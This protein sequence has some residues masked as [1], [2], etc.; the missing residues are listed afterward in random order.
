MTKIFKI[1][2]KVIKIF[3]E[4]LKTPKICHIFLNLHKKRI[5]PIFAA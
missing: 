2:A 3:R 4:P 5:F 1:V